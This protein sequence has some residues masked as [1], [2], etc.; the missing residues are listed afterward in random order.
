MRI[1]FSTVWSGCCLDSLLKFALAVLCSC[2]QIFRTQSILLLGDTDVDYTMIHNSSCC[3][4]VNRDWCTTLLLFTD[5]YAL[6]SVLSETSRLAAMT[7]AVL[8]NYSLYMFALTTLTWRIELRVAGRGFAVD[9]RPSC[10]LSENTTSALQNE[11]Y[12]HNSSPLHD[13]LAH[14]PCCAD[15]DRWCLCSCVLVISPTM[16]LP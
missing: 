11:S 5:A 3:L 10:I 9:Q 16:T 8:H 15:S 13:L 2:C 7:P 1:V 14:F 12:H 4:V 6:L